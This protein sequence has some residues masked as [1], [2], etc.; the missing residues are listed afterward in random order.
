MPRSSAYFA[1]HGSAEEVLQDILAINVA[2][3][4]IPMDPRGEVCLCL[5][6]AD[7]G[8][9]MIHQPSTLGLTQA[10]PAYS[11]KIACIEAATYP[12]AIKL[13]ANDNPAAPACVRRV[14]LTIGS[15]AARARH[16]RPAAEKP[17]PT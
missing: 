12:A 5:L 15:R 2:A 13:A 7:G 9:T 6:R 10:K 8:L 3:T 14:H 4:S 1:V 17:S 16:A 11:N